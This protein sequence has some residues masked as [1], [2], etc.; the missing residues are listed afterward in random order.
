MSSD[1]KALLAGVRALV[2][3]KRASGMRLQVKDGVASQS[4]REEQLIIREHLAVSLSG[5]PA[6][7]GSVV[8]ADRHRLE[9]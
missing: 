3:S 8:L 5:V 1:P 2:P 4:A 9:S 6:S 7:M